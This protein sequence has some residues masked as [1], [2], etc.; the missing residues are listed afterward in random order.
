MDTGSHLRRRTFLTAAAAGAAFSTTTTRAT[1]AVE[2]E[3]C[4]MRDTP[5]GDTESVEHAHL[6]R[7]VV[8]PDDVREQK[9]GEI[10]GSGDPVGIDGEYV[11]EVYLAE[12]D[13]FDYSFWRGVASVGP[14]QEERGRIWLSESFMT[15]TARLLAHERGHNLGYDHTDGFML[16]S[17]PDIDPDTELATES[18]ETAAHTD[19][20][21]LCDWSS[22]DATATL[23]R[24]IGDWRAG[25]LSTGDLGYVL[26]R[27]NAGEGRDIYADDTFVDSLDGLS[28]Y[29]DE[30]R[31]VRAE[32][33]YRPANGDRYDAWETQ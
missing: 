20:L 18:A 30:N 8:S 33:V 13:R 27:W 32:A 17:N 19:G 9:V 11:S 15:E 1:A 7:A 10:T 21:S 26:D 24:M 29:D 22:S 4:V 5:D 31:R 28:E 14:Y 3:L 12:R 16:P 23:G 6:E 2:V 25:R